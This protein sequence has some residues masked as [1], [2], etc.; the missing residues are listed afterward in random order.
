MARHWE[1]PEHV[2][3]GVGGMGW[4]AHICWFLG[5]VFAVLG[6]IAAAA[7]ITLGLGATNWLLLAIA[8]L[9]VGIFPSIGWALGLY[10]NVIEAKGKKEE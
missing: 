6:I 8:V 3:A 2:K 5:I 7:N 1:N 9:G 4:L 10:L